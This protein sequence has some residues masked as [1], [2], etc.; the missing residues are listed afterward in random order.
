MTEPTPS[1][2]NRLTTPEE[3]GLDLS[4]LVPLLRLLANGEPVEID[5]LA[6]EAALTADQVNDRLAAVPDTEYDDAGRII[7]QGLTLRPTNH[8]FTVNDQELYTWCALDTLIFPT[9]LDQAAQ[10]ESTSP[11]SGQTIRVTVGPSGVTAVE[12]TAAVVSLVNPEDMTSIRSAF[13]N[14]VHY[15]TSAEDAQPWLESHPE[16]KVI[17]VADAYQLGATLTR[18]ALDQPDVTTHGSAPSTS[19]CCAH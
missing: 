16:G 4:V 7:G 14:Q 12:P 13:C 18:P 8:R 2:I 17:P 9:L 1:L 10:V 3:T 5:A 11:S 19:P 6:R 15:F